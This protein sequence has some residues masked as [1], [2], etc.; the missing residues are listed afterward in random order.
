MVAQ[1]IAVPLIG[2]A[3]LSTY[4]WMIRNAHDPRKLLRTHRVRMYDVID[5]NTRSSVAYWI[6]ASVVFLALYFCKF[7]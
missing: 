3:S 4:I 6:A 1:T 7:Q 5:E 2:L